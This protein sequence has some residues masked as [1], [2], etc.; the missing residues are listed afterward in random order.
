MMSRRKKRSAETPESSPPSRKDAARSSRRQ[1]PEPDPPRP[2][3][4]LLGIMTAV[5][6]AWLGVLICMAATSMKWRDTGKGVPSN[7]DNFRM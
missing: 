3:R 6:L 1:L 4:L 7:I 5:L 2:S